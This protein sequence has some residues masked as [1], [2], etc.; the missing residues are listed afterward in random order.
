MPDVN[1]NLQ[2]GDPG[3]VP[4][5]GQTSGAGL[6]NTTASPPAV[7]TAPAAPPYT[8][9]NQPTAPAMTAA[10]PADKTVS[11][12][13]ESLI[14]KSSPLM[15]QAEAR[16]AQKM[17]ERG[18]LNSSQAITAGQAAVIDAATP[19]A[20]ADANQATQ[21]ALAN[22]Q[23]AT[24]KYTSD[25]SS[26]TQLQAQQVD[27][28]FKM[29][30]QQ[31]DAQSKLQLQAAHDEASKVIANT[32]ANYKTLMQTSSSAADVYKATIAAISQIYGDASI[33]AAGK[34]RVINNQ[35]SMMTQQ[36]NLIGSVNG[37]DLSGLTN[38]GTMSP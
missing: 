22:Q 2:P 38:F 29:A 26:N 30:F 15:Q 31:A 16:A 25:L 4:P 23:A 17:N 34:A 37:V 35:L 6:M 20:T 9:I 36:L 11:G 32:E 19:I 3:Y 33:D 24:Q 7:S 1:G 5:S 27:N 14:S 28:S 13:I 12:G 21:I 10:V 8:P 18:L